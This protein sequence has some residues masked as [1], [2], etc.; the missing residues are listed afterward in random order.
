VLSI[1]E[2]N[3]KITGYFSGRRTLDKGI[4]S[5]AAIITGIKTLAGSTPAKTQRQLVKVDI[6]S[7]RQMYCSGKARSVMKRTRRSHSVFERLCTI[8]IAYIFSYDDASGLFS[9]FLKI[10]LQRPGVNSCSW[11]SLCKP[12]AI[13]TWLQ[14]GALADNALMRPLL[15]V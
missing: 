7:E 14:R 1:A 6:S 8:F 2:T 5:K 4:S 13:S 11:H 10:L 15:F 9:L 3:K 12:D